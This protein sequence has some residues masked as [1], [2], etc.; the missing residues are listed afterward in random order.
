MTTRDIAL[1]VLVTGALDKDHQK[2]P[3]LMSERVSVTLLLRRLN[4]VVRSSSGPGQFI[5][6]RN[7]ANIA[8]PSLSPTGS[9]NQPHLLLAIARL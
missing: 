2:L 9:I 4:N 1:E 6:L 5:L 7:S 3:A 8:A